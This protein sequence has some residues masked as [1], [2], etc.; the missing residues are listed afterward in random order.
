M[1]PWNRSILFLS[2]LNAVIDAVWRTY[3]GDD[4]DV[5]RRYPRLT[6]VSFL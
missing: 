4:C 5:L 2:V 1:L 6:N 3:L